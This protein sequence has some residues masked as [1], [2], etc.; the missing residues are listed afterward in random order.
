MPKVKWTAKEGDD[1]ITAADI[2]G[3]EV[4]GGVYTG[5][6]P[7]AGVYRFKLKR[8]KFEKFGTGNSG[9][10]N[11]LA[12]DGSWKP[13]HAKFDG[14]GLWDRVVLSKA[15]AAFVK[16]FGVALGVSAVDLINNT[17]VDDDGYVTAI[18]KLKLVDREPLL[19]VNVKRDPD[20][21]Y[22]DRLT[23]SGTGYIA[24]TVEADATPAP[25]AAPAAETGKKAKGGKKG[26]A[27]AA[28]A[29]DSEPPF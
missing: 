24:V 6:L 17:V 16:A 18:G 19:Y 9:F 12:L 27:K 14:C 5:P 7:P 21:D 1:A 15:G 10:N 8:S 23:K 11:R 4:D 29:D 13:E 2:D 3:A 26:K 28:A 20:P 22:H 25:E